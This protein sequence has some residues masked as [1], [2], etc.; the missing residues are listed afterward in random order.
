LR[1]DTHQ[2][3]DPELCGRAVSVE[4]GASRVELTTISRMAVDGTGL[5]HGG[6]VFGLA[7]YAAMIAVNDPNVVLGGAQVRFLKPVATGE[8][9]TATARV[10]SSEGKKRMVPVT[11]ERAS[12][13]A[14]FTGTFTCFVL[15]RHVLS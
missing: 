1:I 4:K 5:V 14:V 8:I 2:K 15:D 13:E 7:D 12:G 6:F 3:I 11:V 9:L 10:E